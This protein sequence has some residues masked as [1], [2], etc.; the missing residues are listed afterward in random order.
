M[1]AATDVELCGPGGLRHGL[2]LHV[3]LRLE[4]SSGLP[5]PGLLP[6]SIPPGHYRGRAPGT[7][8]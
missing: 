2:A 5:H 4:R 1:P 3:V 7:E 6:S 8:K